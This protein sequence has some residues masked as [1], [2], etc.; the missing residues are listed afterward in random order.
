MNT[1]PPVDVLSEPSAAIPDSEDPL[2]Q[3]LQ[4]KDLASSNGDQGSSLTIQEVLNRFQ[5]VKRVDLA[6][7]FNVL[8]YWNN[9]NNEFAV[10]KE[11]AFAIYFAAATQ[12]SVERCFSAL[13]FIL[14]D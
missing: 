5:K 13:R 3:L 4:N 6:E 7:K 11:T 12:V 14:S 1:N 9:M 8:Q 10:L 2:E